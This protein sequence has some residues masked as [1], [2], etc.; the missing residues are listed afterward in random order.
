MF[1]IYVYTYC[2]DK[3]EKSIVDEDLAINFFK[4]FSACEDVKQ[5]TMI[6]GLTGEILYAYDTKKGWDVFN[7]QTIE[8]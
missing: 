3:I 7:G 1:T 8:L 2:G 6:N 5:V 4:A